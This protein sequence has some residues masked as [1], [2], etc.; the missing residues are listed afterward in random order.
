VALGSSRVDYVDSDPTRLRIAQALGANPL[1]LSG[2]SR[3]LGQRKPISRERYLIS[4]D[5]TG[6]SAGLSC[7]LES[8]APG[9]YCTA[10]AFYMRKGTPLPLWKMYM[11]SATLHV[12]VSHPRATIPAVLALIASGKFEPHKVT[13][14]IADWADADRALLESSTKIVLRRPMLAAAD[15][16]AQLTV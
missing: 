2:V 7:A 9:G 13:T 16:R 5:A 3:W 10:L 14:L 12:G 8:L 11:K 15:R 6:T 1:E 4:V